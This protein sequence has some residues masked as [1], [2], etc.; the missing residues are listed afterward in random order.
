M[1]STIDDASF[2][3]TNG[4]CIGS[5]NVCGLKRRIHYPEFIET[6]KKFDVICMSETTPTLFPVKA[7]RFSMRL[8]DKNSPAHREE[9]AF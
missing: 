4:L 9:L 3:Q 6:I 5:L 7:L 2:Y 1:P 8:G